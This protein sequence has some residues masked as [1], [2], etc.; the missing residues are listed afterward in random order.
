MPERK[1]L[2]I[3]FEVAEEIIKDQKGV[4]VQESSFIKKSK[5]VDRLIFLTPAIIPDEDGQQDYMEG[6]AW[7]HRILRLHADSRGLTLPTISEDNFLSWIDSRYEF[8][9][10]NEKS[11]RHRKRLNVLGKEASELFVFL[12]GAKPLKAGG[13]ELLMGVY[14]IW[15]LL[16]RN[17]GA[18]ASSDFVY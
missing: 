3:I 6:A 16:V 7:T 5:W 4:N 18:K 11:E 15:S 17:A 1:L 12:E 13:Y 2:D 9:Q 8:I 14:D 10:N